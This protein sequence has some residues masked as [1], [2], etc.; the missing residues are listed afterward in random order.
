MSEVDLKS[1]FKG[2]LFIEER[3]PIHQCLY[4]LVLWLTS[5]LFYAL[6]LRGAIFV[7]VSL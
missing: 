3:L 5:S 7:V 2:V 4:S 1:E 6:A